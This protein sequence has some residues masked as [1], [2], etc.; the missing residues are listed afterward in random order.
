MI[1]KALL[2]CDSLK[3]IIKLYKADRFKSGKGQKNFVKVTNKNR[4]VTHQN[5]QCTKIVSLDTTTI[6][7]HRVILT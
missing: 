3:D 7:V 2:K 6:L 5:I 4:K 1:E